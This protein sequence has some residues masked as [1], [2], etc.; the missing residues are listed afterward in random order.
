MPQGDYDLGLI[1]DFPEGRVAAREVAGKP[2]LMLRE[3][4]RSRR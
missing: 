1:G 2:I 3:G 4:R